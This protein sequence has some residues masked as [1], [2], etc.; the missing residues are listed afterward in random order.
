MNEIL[1]SS[2]EKPH[3]SAHPI[4]FFFLS[5]PYGIVQGYVQVALAFLYTKKGISVEAVAA[6]VGA[7]LLPNI[8]KFLWAPLVDTTLTLKKWYILSSIVTAAGILAS[9]V[10]V[11]KE[12]N[13]PLLMLIIVIAN[14]GVSF[15]YM[16]SC[17]LAAHDTPE[18]MKGRVG[19]YNQAGNL[20]G[21]GFGGGVGLW[22][23]QNVNAIWLSPA[24]LG[25][26]CLLTCFALAFVREPV[27]TI[28]AEK[29]IKTVSNLLKDIWITV[30]AKMGFLAFFLCFLPLGTGA[31]QNLWAAIAGD[32]HAGANTV[33]FVTGIASGFITMGGC[34]MGGWICDRMDR[35]KAYIVFALSSV[36]CAVAM[37]YSP[38]TEIM[39]IAWTSIYAFSLGLCYAAFT[40]FVLEAIGKGAAG[41]KYTIYAS[42]SNFPIWYMTIFEG[43]VH[44]RYGAKGLL[45]AE[46][47]CG[48]L[49]ILAFLLLA[50]IANRKKVAA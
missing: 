41:T 14:I 25:I 16:A 23:W 32:W 6:L 8:I 38:Y 30:K 35:Q 21:T 31:A 3:K 29:V 20:G 2:L 27:I 12:S 11:I 24:V 44:T 37:A 50:K 7:G 39:Y 46:A 17:G 26:V 45:N 5:L 18:E 33:E 10:I 4:V 49:G 42:L 15:N 22:L 13:L 48:V 43:W 28:K 1:S 40:A 47:I 19:G 36:V 34:F 9:G